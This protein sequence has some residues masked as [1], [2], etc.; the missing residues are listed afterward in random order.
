MGNYFTFR[1]HSVSVMGNNWLLKYKRLTMNFPCTY[2]QTFEYQT[3]SE[4]MG[5]VGL[6]LNIK[7]AMKKM[8]VVG[9]HEKSSG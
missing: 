9:F 5:V 3:G 6:P 2:C 7:L 1:E 4:E 8:G